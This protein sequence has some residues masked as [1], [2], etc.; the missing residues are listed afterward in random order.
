MVIEGRLKKSKEKGV[1]DGIELTDRKV[2]RGWSRLPAIATPAKR[3][4]K[5]KCL[6]RNLHH[7]PH[8]HRPSFYQYFY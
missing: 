1:A 2:Q 6:L 5:R 8:H 3:D 4:G 7:H